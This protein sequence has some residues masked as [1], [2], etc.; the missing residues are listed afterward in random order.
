MIR[1]DNE[2]HTDADAREALLD[3]AFGPAR[4]EKTCQ[5]LRDGR[6]PAEG[7]SFAAKEN[8]E[9]I[10]T[11]RFWH[12]SAGPGRRALL[13]GPLAIA[14]SH[15][16]RGIGGGLMKVGLAKATALGHTAVLLVGD[17]PYYARFGFERRFTEG[18]WLPGPVE[19]SRFLGRELVTGSLAGAFG[20]VNP[21]GEEIVP[22]GLWPRV[23]ELMAADETR[24]AA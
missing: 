8:G 18:L 2:L 3:A 15:E 17:E 16:G 14:R 12:I 1:I 9:V 23:R 11:L 20:M 7:L 5:R 6:L 10:G 22:H 21:T 4:F 19:R 13:L 24:A